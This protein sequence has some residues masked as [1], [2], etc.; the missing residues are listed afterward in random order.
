MLLRKYLS[1]I[2]I[3]SAKIDL[4]LPKDTY[5]PGEHI[6]GYFLLKGGTIE[7]TLKRIDCDL[8]RIEEG[9]GQEDIV[10]TTTILTSKIIQSEEANQIPFTF[11]LP[12]SIQASNEEV[13]YRFK[14]KLTF[15][16]GVKSIDQDNIVIL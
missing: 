7:Q 2:G 12:A 16:E 8:V 3:G 11:C 13:S 14:T 1:L 5:V 15:N 4:I 9:K 6:N 10:D